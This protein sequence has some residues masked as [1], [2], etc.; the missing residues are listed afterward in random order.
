MKNRIRIFATLIATLICVGGFSVTAY[1]DGGEDCDYYTEPETTESAEP[2]ETATESQSL[3]PDGN[4]TLVDDIE[5]E[6]TEDKQFITV[7][8]KD[9]NYF[10]IVIDRS[11]D[12]DNVYFLNL[13]DEADLLALID[14][15]D[16]Q[17]Q[18]TSSVTET[19]AEPEETAETADTDKQQ[20]DETG[21][22]S[23]LVV[24]LVVL[25]IGGGG[26]LVY[27]KLIKPKKNIKG[28]VDLD[29]YDFDE[30]T[31]DSDVDEPEGDLREEK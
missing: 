23:A 17:S 4:L 26:A 18:N 13:V 12:T 7:Q 29:E 16:I 1:A 6:A 9:G 21:N 3:T 31:E 19:T 15:E 20:E 28:G 10:Y 5:S 24:L 25:L 2:E 8:T 14:D 11:D 30:D 27:F 22:N